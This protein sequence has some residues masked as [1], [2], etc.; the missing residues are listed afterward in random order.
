MIEEYNP[1]TNIKRMIFE[2]EYLIKNNKNLLSI[3]KRENNLI[4]VYKN[5]FKICYI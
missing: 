3:G 2:D 4:L 5:P 1:S